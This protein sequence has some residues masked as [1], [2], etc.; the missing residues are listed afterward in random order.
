MGYSSEN[1]ILTQS[2]IKAKNRISKT[3]MEYVANDLS[4]EEY[5]MEMAKAA[6]QLNTAIQNIKIYKNRD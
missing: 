3:I 4:F 6:F 5:S 2:V 1:K